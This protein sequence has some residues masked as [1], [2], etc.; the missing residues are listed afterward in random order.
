[1]RLPLKYIIS[2]FVA[3]S[4]I[5]LASSQ[6]FKELRSL[7]KFLVGFLFLVLLRLIVYNR[8][9]SSAKCLVVENFMQEFKPFMYTKNN[10][11]PSTEP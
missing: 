6:W 8:F 3:F 7:F 5:L 4:D 1:M 10:N 11:G 2:V 9:V